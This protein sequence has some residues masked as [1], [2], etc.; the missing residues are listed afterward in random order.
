M[1]GRIVAGAY[2]QMGLVNGPIVATLDD[3][4]PLAIELATNHE[5][6]QEVRDEIGGATE[7]NLFRDTAAIRSFESFFEAALIARDQGR[8]LPEGWM[9]ENKNAAC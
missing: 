9:P 2:R 4:A 3:Y 1:R 8:I 7:T 5:R 6:R